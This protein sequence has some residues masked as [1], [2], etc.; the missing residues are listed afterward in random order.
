[1]DNAKFWAIIDSANA[2][3][4]GDMDRKCS[5]LEKAL[6]PLGTE[7]IGSFIDH[8]DACMDAAYTWGL[9]GAAYVI[10]GGCSDDSFMDFRSTLISHGR[11]VF[12][13]ALKDPESLADVGLDPEDAVY[14]G[15]GYIAPSLYQKR[16]GTPRTR[17]GAHPKEPSGV[18]WN[19]E[20][21]PTLF[22]RLS[23]RYDAAT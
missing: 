2:A 10:H 5:L 3:S 18:E 6:T 20:D 14:E 8:F 23:K 15:Y 22:P 16:S 21:L 4:G 12:E 11:M 1:M 19:E 7:E 13:A 9:W 17:S